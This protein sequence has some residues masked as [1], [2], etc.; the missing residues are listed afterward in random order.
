MHCLYTDLRASINS[1]QGTY[2]TTVTARDG[3]KML[4]APVEYFIDAGSYKLVF[5]SKSKL[6]Q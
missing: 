4:N 5:T 1:A 3:D 2:V 6:S